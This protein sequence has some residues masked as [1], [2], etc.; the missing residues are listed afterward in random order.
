MDVQDRLFEVLDAL[1]SSATTVTSLRQPVAL[2]EAVKLAVELGMDANTNDA[3]VHAIRDRVEMFAQHLALEAHFQRH[4]AAR[5][6]LA[7]LAV[8]AA[9]L[10][11][12]P[13]ADDEDLLRAAAAE[14]GA[15]MPDAS[16]ADVLIYAVGMRSKSRVTAWPRSPSRP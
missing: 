1:D 13:L 15:S 11:A 7:E 10:D 2:R 8:A 4:P 16:G 14:L 12:H 5:P 9:Q 6:T 3:T